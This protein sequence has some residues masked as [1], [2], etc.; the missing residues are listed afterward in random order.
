[1]D[2]EPAAKGVT[3]FCIRVRTVIDARA[4]FGRRR[5]PWGLAV[6]PLVPV[7]STERPA[8][9]VIPAT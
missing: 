5:C 1:M 3:E 6:R 7:R 9:E 8:G 2:R 4:T